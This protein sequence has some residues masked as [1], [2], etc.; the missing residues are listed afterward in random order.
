MK[1]PLTSTS[2]GT[3]TCFLFTRTTVKASGLPSSTAA[4]NYNLSKQYTSIFILYWEYLSEYLS[5]L[6]THT[7]WCY[8]QRT[9]FG[10]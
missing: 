3:E 1:L 5:A 2:H 8:H 10:L 9:G 6:V 7:A 4:V